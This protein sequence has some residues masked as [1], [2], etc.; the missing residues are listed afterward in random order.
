MSNTITSEEVN[1]L[2][3]RYLL[4]SGYTHA[5]FTFGHEALVLE[6]GIDGLGVPPGALLGFLQR[7]VSYAEIEA[8]VAR[9][10][11]ERLKEG[12]DR[13]ENGSMLAETVSSAD[14]KSHMQ[15][16]VINLAEVHRTLVNRPRRRQRTA[17][18]VPAV[19]QE[20][21]PAEAMA[22]DALYTVHDTEVTVLYGHTAEVFAIAWNPTQEHL[23]ASGSGDATARIWAIPSGPSG[24]TAVAPPL[25]LRHQSLDEHRPLTSPTLSSATD[26]VTMDSASGAPVASS[27][28]R[29]RR[30]PSRDVTALDWSPDGRRI[31]S[32]SYDGATRVWTS[33]G[34]L[35]RLFSIH[36]GPV[37]SLKWNS[38]GKRLATS[39]VDHSVAIWDVFSGRL[40]QQVQ[41]HRAPVLD[42]D[43][44]SEDTFASSG[45]DKMIYVFRVGESKPLRMFYG[46]QDEVNSIKWDPTGTLL[47]SGSDD[48]TV[49]IWRPIRQSG[50]ATTPGETS[51]DGPSSGSSCDYLVH[52]YTDHTKEVY[53]VRWSPGAN[54]YFASASFD[55]TVRVWDPAH[56]G[57]APTMVLS[58]H[59]G[60]VF[61]IAFSPCGQYL[62][63]GS[64]DRNMLIWS[65]REG[66]KLIRV[67]R[68]QGGIFE[69]AWNVTGSKVAA[70]LSNGTVAITDLRL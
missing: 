65:L 59:F 70:A 11:A 48:C 42:V 57:G 30:A 41:L 10:H 21:A 39:S 31:A 45:S 62:A 54:R 50:L 53:A 64:S 5:A 17:V 55:S 49:K 14:K 3:F 47:A 7:G 51:P 35:E 4:E 44:Q 18:E 40:E 38:T 43:W 58:R 25:E 2:I 27:G 23:L 13:R 63:S 8:H 36:T 60:P 26:D 15:P 61:S 33:T 37:L 69:V 19:K 20:T 6:S 66:G 28:S 52:D 24:R 32:A 34:A 9:L 12:A 67:L 16:V 46:H 1:Y 22:A 29:Q 56:A 68:C